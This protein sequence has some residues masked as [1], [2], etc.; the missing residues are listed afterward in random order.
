MKKTLALLLALLMSLALFAGCSSEAPAAE[1]TTGEETTTTQDTEV[2]SD[3]KVTIRLVS[4]STDANQTSILED[5]IKANVQA[6]FPNVTMEYEP[7]GGG[8]DLA[9]KM[10]TYNSTDDLPDIWYSTA[11][12]AFPIMQAGNQLDLTS[13]ITESG[14]IDN[15]NTPE[16]LEFKDGGIYTVTSGADSYFTGKIFYN[17][18]IFAANNIEVPT[19]WDEFLTACDTLKA[20]GVTPISLMGKG[21][22]APQ[23]F[24]VQ[25]FTQLHDPS[26]IDALLANET[27][28]SNPVILEAVSKIETLVAN[29]YLPEGVS[30]LDYGPAL[31][32]FTSG[33]SAM[34]MGFTWE[35]PNLQSNEAIDIMQWPQMVDDVNPDDV[36][37]VW[38][39]PLN[40]YAVNA[41]GENVEIAV[42]VAAFCAQQEA[43][44]YASSGGS[45][46]LVSEIALPEPSALMTKNLE[47][48]DAAA[49]KSANIYLNAMD[50]KVAASFGQYGSSLLAGGYT[51]EDF[52]ANMNEDW[53][54]NEYF[55]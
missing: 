13:Y 5:Y 45:T 2:A 19:T 36:L 28:F 37:S 48:Y 18:D 49:T 44:F 23:L 39:S 33:Q 42:Q 21:G 25:T 51:A 41:K 53:L 14:F 6:A 29:G 35:V 32:M 55:N 11:D 43:N 54:E 50:A 7:G 46:N 22:W 8:E 15:Y 24:L 27:D 4:I 26:V 47:I 3:E 20:A 9:N 38:G 30:N 12:Y 52:V 31:E 1:A 16:L 17:K 40:G 34:Y 10:K